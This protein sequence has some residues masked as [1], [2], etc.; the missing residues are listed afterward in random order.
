MRHIDKLDVVEIGD[1]LG[2]FEDF[3]ISAGGEIEF[4][5]SVLEESFGGGSEFEQG[6]NLVRAE[7]GVVKIGF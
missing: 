4:V 5:G 3:K 2:D 1:S 6:R 7:R